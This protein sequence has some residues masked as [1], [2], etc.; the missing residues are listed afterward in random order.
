MCTVKT[1]DD[2]QRNCPKHVVL[3][4]K[5]KL[6]KL[7]HLVGFI[8]RSA[9]VCIYEI[10]PAQAVTLLT[11]IWQIISSNLG[12][13]TIFFFFVSVPHIKQRRLSDHLLNILPFEALSSQI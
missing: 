9:Y 10:K 4:Q 3:F 8:I 11:G 2:G 12:W 6:E 1:R 5:N 7:V 13:G